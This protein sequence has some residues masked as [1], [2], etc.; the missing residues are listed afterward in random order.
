M[1]P[2]GYVADRAFCGLSVGGWI[3]IVCIV[4]ALSWRLFQ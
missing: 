3:V 1:T 4:C 2:I